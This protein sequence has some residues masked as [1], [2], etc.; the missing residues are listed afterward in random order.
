MR[1]DDRFFGG[2]KG[3]AAKAKAGMAKQY[4]LSEG[5]RIYHALLQKRKDAQRGAEKTHG[6][7]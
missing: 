1:G 7:R 5:T 4:G 2:K 6:R 3:S